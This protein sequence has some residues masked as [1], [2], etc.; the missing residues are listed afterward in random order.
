MVSGLDFIFFRFRLDI[1]PIEILELN[2][3]KALNRQ[4][5]IRPGL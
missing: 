2:K 4:Q 3:L 5:S 1:R